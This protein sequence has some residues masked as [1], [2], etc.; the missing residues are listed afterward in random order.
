MWECQFRDPALGN[1][2]PPYL[3]SIAYTDEACF[4]EGNSYN[5]AA[6]DAVLKLRQRLQHLF[7]GKRPLTEEVDSKYGVFHRQIM[8]NE[9]LYYSEVSLREEEPGLS[10]NN[11]V[12]CSILVDFHFGQGKV[13]QIGWCVDEKKGHMT[14]LDE[15]CR[16]IA[17]QQAE[18]SSQT[19]KGIQ[20]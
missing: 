20:Q 1:V 11:A 19:R 6:D 10:L 5:E 14:S 15:K 13:K 2:W 18:E 7:G 8:E 16:Y 17:R 12:D 4:G 9:G 3:A